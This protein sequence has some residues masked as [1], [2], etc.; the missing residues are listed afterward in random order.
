MRGFFVVGDF[1]CRGSS[2]EPLR[3]TF[4]SLDYVTKSSKR[5]W[6][7]FFG[8][9]G[10]LMDE[11]SH[12]LVSI[13]EILDTIAQTRAAKVKIFSI[14]I[15]RKLLDFCIHDQ[16]IEMNFFQVKRLL[17]WVTINSCKIFLK[18][19]RHW[20]LNYFVTSIQNEFYFEWI[21]KKYLHISKIRK[22]RYFLWNLQS[23]T[24]KYHMNFIKIL[25][26]LQNFHEKLQLYFLNFENIQDF[27]I[28]V[29]FV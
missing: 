4:I 14:S 3:A 20:I 22:V 10:E 12:C 29:Y 25:Q 1:M 17:W 21:E 6:R 27:Y 28:N 8:L 19:F 26:I 2:V 15:W 18:N 16:K 23:N 5:N 7:E 13:F 11:N 24:V 9:V